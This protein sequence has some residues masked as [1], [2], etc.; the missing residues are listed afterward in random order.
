VGAAATYDPTHGQVVLFGGSAMPSVDAGAT[1]SAPLSD[2][3]AWDGN[4]WTKLNPHRSPAARTS[5]VLVFDNALNRSVLFGGATASGVL[6]DTWLWNGSEWAPATTSTPPAPR[7]A[8]AAGYDPVGQQIVVYGGGTATGAALSDT[9]LLSIAPPIVLTPT[10]PSTSG[11]AGSSTPPPT[12]PTTTSHPATTKAGPSRPG[13]T[14]TAPVTVSAS[15]P[16]LTPAQGSP[17]LAAAVQTAHRGEPVLLTASGFKPGA[18]VTITFH[19]DPSLV[20]KR[21]ADAKG[22][23][24]ATVTVPDGA[25]FGQHHFVAVGETSLGQMREA[26]TPIQVDGPALLVPKSGSKVVTA[27][28]VGIAIVLPFLTWSVLGLRSRWRQR[29]AARAGS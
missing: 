29:S 7:S 3:W 1:T 15:T 23:F 22:A 28:M 25:A 2:M 21:P 11:L 4:T 17:S 16:G 6:N 8:A 14:T 10:T 18:L 20:G 24:V 5:G 12:T 9:T 13:A 26:S 27:V 19:S